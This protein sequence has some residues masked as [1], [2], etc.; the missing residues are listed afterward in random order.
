MEA[1]QQDKFYALEKV[2][3]QW[4]SF[5]H[6]ET[7]VND[8]TVLKFAGRLKDM[9]VPKSFVPAAYSI[10]V[11]TAGTMPASINHSDYDIQTNGGFFTSPDFL[12]Q[13]R[14]TENTYVEYYNITFS[15]KIA[16]ELATQFSLAQ[17]AQIYARPVWQMN[18][19]KTQ[20]IVHYIEL[21]REVI[22]DKN[23]E[24]A[25]QLV[26]SLVLYLAGDYINDQPRLP[27]LSR[28][29]EI[30]GKFLALVDA[31]CEQQHS[32][33]W[34][35]SELCLSTRYVANTVKETL[36]MTASTCIER[37]LMQ[38]AKTILSTST[39]PIAEIAETL[40]FQNQSHFGTFF[41]RHEGCSPKDFRTQHYR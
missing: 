28:N 4:A 31:N 17:V 33:D 2:N 3:F 16:Q 15:Q 20:R 38:R 23:R 32:L 25:I 8:L 5:I 19:R 6:G 22:D 13:V 27:Q 11:V 26:K 40:G 10:N 29:E 24:A 41:K 37:A 14:E 39:T 1:Q 7:V 30:T 34:Y 36:G 35:A 21:L 12:L 18:G 9:S